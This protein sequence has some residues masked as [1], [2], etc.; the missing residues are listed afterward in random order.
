MAGVVNADREATLRLV[1][2]G[3]SGKQQEIEAIIDTG[4]TGFL[5]LPAALVSALVYRF[6]KTYPVGFV[7]CYTGAWQAN[8]DDRSSP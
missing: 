2:A 3:P 1:I 5:T 6:V 8:P 4:F 7:S